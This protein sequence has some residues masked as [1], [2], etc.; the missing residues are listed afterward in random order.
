MTT[1]ILVTGGTGTLG[2]P[3]AQRLRDAGG[4]VTVLS[5]HPRES[6]EGIRHRS[7]PPARKVTTTGR[8]RNTGPRRGSRFARVYPT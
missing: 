3:V 4:G 7:P 5:R 1:S 6:A 8:W 2:R